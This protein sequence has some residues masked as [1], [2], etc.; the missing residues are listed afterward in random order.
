[1][2]DVETHELSRLTTG[3]DLMPYWE[4]TTP[5]ISPDGSTV[6]YAEAGWILLVPAAGGPPR[7]LV[8]AGSPIW[9][10]DDRLVV[11]VDRDDCSR[12]AVV[13]VTDP[14]PHRLASSSADLDTVGDEGEA[15]LSPDG[16]LVAY[17]F[18]PRADLNRTEIRVVD[19]ETGNAR[20]LT[21]TAA[22]HDRGPVWSPD[23]MLVVFRAQREEWDELR[24]VDVETCEARVL[25]AADADLSEPVWHPD[26]TK[27]AAIR[28]AR[29]THDLVTVDAATGA[30]E[31]VA[32]GGVWATP[33]WTAAGAIVA[34]YEDHGTAPE[35]RLVSGGVAAS[36]AA[37]APRAVRA[38]PHVR[39]EEIAFRSSDG[40]EIEALLFRPAAGVRP[41]PAVVYPHGGPT[42]RYGDDWDGHA[43]YFVDKGY[44][45]LAHNFRGS[46]GR[47]KTFERANFDDWGGGDMR[48]CLAWRS[49][50]RATARTCRSAQR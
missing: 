20:A 41:A 31:V 40:L 23:G 2:L 19:V 25:A 10:S 48:D 28:F 14:W 43:Q 49:S 12:L 24:A 9:L 35:I 33:Q 36:I 29:F 15:A 18:G 21:G 22:T 26:G 37:P 16:R 50:A 34:M 45:W 7:K 32:A 5:T 38:A 27:L 6:A 46:I 30:V 4:D 11:S 8:E 17:S 39:P 42:D 44:A 13:S 3:R 1:L 47:G